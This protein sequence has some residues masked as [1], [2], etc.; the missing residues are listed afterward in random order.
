[1][2]GND[3]QQKQIFSFPIRA[4]IKEA[5]EKLAAADRRSVSSY[6]EI[7]LEDHIEA[8]RKEGKKR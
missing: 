1:V 8:K 6:I 5:L 7:A 3:A 4:D 2:I